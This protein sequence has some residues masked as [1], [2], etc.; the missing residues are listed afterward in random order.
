MKREVQVRY[1]VVEIK[2][3]DEDSW[4]PIGVLGQDHAG[5]WAK[6]LKAEKRYQAFHK[7]I[8][9]SNSFEFDYPDPEEESGIRKRRINVHDPFFLLFAHQFWSN[10]QIR[11]TTPKI[12]KIDIETENDNPRDRFERLAQESEIARDGVFSLEITP[13]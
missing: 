3:S 11:Y 8:L 9:D 2:E 6:F 4:T 10:D 12:I 1:V 5:V 7:Q 13:F